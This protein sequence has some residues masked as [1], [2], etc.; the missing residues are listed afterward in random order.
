MAATLRQTTRV[1]PLAPTT[2][3]LGTSVMK[4]VIVVA[5]LLAFAVP[6]FGGTDHIFVS[7]EKGGGL[8][9]LNATDY[10]TVQ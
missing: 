5:G 2:P 7:N 4:P 6:A 8:S 1:E 9:V 3:A 10:G